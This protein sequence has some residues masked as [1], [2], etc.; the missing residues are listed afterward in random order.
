MDGESKPLKIVELPRP[1]TVIYYVRASAVL[2]PKGGCDFRPCP[3]LNCSRGSRSDYEL[4]VSTA[5]VYE[6]PITVQQ[7]GERLNVTG[8]SRFTLAV[9]IIPQL[10]K[11]R[12][13]EDALF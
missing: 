4:R 11:V 2:V 9:G 10:P 5:L 1:W 13:F 6:L 3:S 7:V 8:D 12:F